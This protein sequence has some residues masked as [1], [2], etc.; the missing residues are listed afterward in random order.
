MQDQFHGVETEVVTDN[1]NLI[2]SVTTPNPIPLD[3]SSAP[4]QTN[5]QTSSQPSNVSPTASPLNTNVVSSPVLSSKSLTS[6]SSA[7]FTSKKKVDDDIESPAYLK[8]K[9]EHEKELKEKAKNAEERQQRARERAKQE[10]E[11]LTQQRTKEIQSRKAANRCSEREAMFL[12]S[13]EVPP[14]EDRV[15]DAVGKLIELSSKDISSPSSA[16]TKRMSTSDSDVSTV[17]TATTEVD[18]A[19]NN[20]KSSSLKKDTRRMRELLLRLTHSAPLT[21]L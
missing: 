3:I 11:Q 4:V 6:S 21:T 8:W 7:S 5:P 18:A 16:R 13:R 14:S 9:E 2:G 12:K 10:L 20:T 19:T 1:Q 15:W 17:D